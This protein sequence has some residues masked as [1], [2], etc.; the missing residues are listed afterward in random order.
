MA[1]KISTTRSSNSSA[2][3]DGIYQLL[4][5]DAVEGTS[6]SGNEQITLS[7]SVLRGG[8]PVGRSIRHYL[9]FDDP[10]DKEKKNQWKW[11]QLHEALELDEGQE[12]TATFYKGKKVYATLNSEEYQ[13]RINNKVRYFMTPE[14]ALSKLEEQVSDGLDDFDTSVSD[15]DD[16]ESEEEVISRPKATRGRPRTQQVAELEEEDMPL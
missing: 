10:R 3:P 2:L 15:I 9:T 6:S 16:D 11:D 4:I 7:L 13:G 8:R 5:T 14:A 1:R 12:I